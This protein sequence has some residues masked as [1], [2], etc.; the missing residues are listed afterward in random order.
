MTGTRASPPAV[1]FG[2]HRTRYRTRC[3][4]SGCRVSLQQ[5]DGGAFARKSI[6]GAATDAALGSIVY[7]GKDLSPED[8]SLFIVRQ[9]YVSPY[10]AGFNL[11]VLEAIASGLP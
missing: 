1:A 9:T 7:L 10:H 3:C 4:S 11:P 6:D 2:R 5:S 8:L